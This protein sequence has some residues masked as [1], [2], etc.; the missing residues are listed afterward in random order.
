MD[1]KYILALLG[2]DSSL[3]IVEPV[4]NFSDKEI[5]INA[6]LVDDNPRIC[7][8]CKSN[9]VIIKDKEIVKINISAYS[10]AFSQKIILCLKKRKYF[11]KKCKKTYSQ[12]NKISSNRKL[13]STAI[14]WQIYNETKNLV[15]FSKIANDLKISEGAVRYIFNSLKTEGRKA[16][17]ITLCVDE[18]KF[19]SDLGK[20][21]CVLSNPYN[22]DIVDVIASRLTPVLNEY[23]N[24][25]SQKE[26]DS[27]KFFVS[28]MYE[29]YRTIKKR[30][31]KNAI[32]IID[33]FHITK[34]FTETIQI[35][36]KNL[37]KHYDSKTFEYKFL[38]MNWKLFL[39]NPYNK[40]NYGLLGKTYYNKENNE[41][42]DFK[43]ALNLMML[44]S[45]DLCL[46]YSIYSDYCHY[47]VRGNNVEKTKESLDF[48]VNRCLQSN[49]HLIEKIGLTLLNFYD[50][51][52]NT[53]SNVNLGNYSN[54]IAESINAKID[55]LITI[56]NGIRS[57]ATLRKRLL[58]L[59][60]K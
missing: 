25:I 14:S 3:F 6:E 31:F 44:K 53:Y 26:R 21:I 40:N 47:L 29:G 19:N 38:K 17:P 32:H 22:G 36:R 9:D 54:A 24:G 33:Y 56:S 37:M 57:F 30:F 49:C 1:D 35:L 59:S 5:T 10:S 20:Y 46:A 48:I 11:C 55:K 7:K 45:P 58:H 23:F 28:D 42:L 39:L 12:S 13:I 15:S 2:L 50:E 43:E 41:Y 16:M 18:K 4:I 8:N 27:V 52:V 60:K 51:I 34:L